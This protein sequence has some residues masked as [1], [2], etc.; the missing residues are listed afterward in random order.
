MCLICAADA[1][2]QAS[3]HQ[4]GYDEKWAS[5]GGMNPHENTRK[6]Q[7]SGLKANPHIVL[8]QDRIIFQQI[9]GQGNPPLA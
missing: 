7:V 8:A 2:L 5:A 3:I 1:P 9:N 4:R 6:Q